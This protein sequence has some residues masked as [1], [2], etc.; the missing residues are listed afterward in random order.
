MEKNQMAMSD[1][2][3]LLRQ[4]VIS[5]ADVPRVLPLGRNGVYEA[6]RKGEIESIRIGRKIMIPTAALRRKL[7]MAG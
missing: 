7:G 1:L 2:E 4:A 3:K 5:P 6:I